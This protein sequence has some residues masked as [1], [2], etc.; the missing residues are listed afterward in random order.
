M[1]LQDPGDEQGLVLRASPQCLLRSHQGLARTLALQLHECPFPAA[2][3][4]PRSP[5]WWRWL[6]PCCSTWDPVTSWPVVP[7][8]QERIPGQRWQPRGG[9]QQLKLAQSSLAQGHRELSPRSGS[10]PLFLCR[11]CTALL[12]P[13]GARPGVPACAALSCSLPCSSRWPWS[14]SGRQ[15]PRST[16]CRQL[17][18]R[19]EALRAPLRAAAAW[20]GADHRRLWAGGGAAPPRQ[21][22]PAAAEAGRAL[23]SGQR[24]DG[25]RR[26]G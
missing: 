15:R 18:T 7:P 6:L 8:P 11:S 10:C 16:L 2:L 3:C 14:R 13:A 1:E 23:G 25:E 4:S 12:G 20:R 9:G 22:L 17:G 19:P 26:M 21:E 5:G 24:Q